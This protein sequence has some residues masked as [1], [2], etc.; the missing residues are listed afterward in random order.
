MS[1][2]VKL[3]FLNLPGDF[4]LGQ[5]LAKGSDPTI[6]QGMIDPENPHIAAAGLTIPAL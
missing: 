2:L 1:H 5:T 4:R 3:H 6:D